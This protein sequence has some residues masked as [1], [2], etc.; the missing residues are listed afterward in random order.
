MDVGP[1]VVPDTETSKL[2]EPGERALDNPTPPSQAATVGC[3][4]P[5]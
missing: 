5:H 1:F 3:A 4:A 2:A